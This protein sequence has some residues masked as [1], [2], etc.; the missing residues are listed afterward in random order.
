MCGNESQIKV[1]SDEGLGLVSLD[2]IKDKIVGSRLVK[3][4][5]SREKLEEITVID[6]ISEEDSLFERKIDVYDALQLRLTESQNQ[7]E[8]L[9]KKE[10]N[11]NSIEVRKTI[12]ERDAYAE[13]IHLMRKTYF[14]F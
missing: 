5:E 11:P 12:L 10:M 1:N 4:K 6:I 14:D 13:A 8:Y 3:Y 7:L 2:E 9:R